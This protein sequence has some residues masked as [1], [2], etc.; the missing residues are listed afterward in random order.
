MHQIWVG[1]LP[2]PEKWMRTWR[3]MHPD[4][5]YR[6]WGNEDL[7]NGEWRNK[8]HMD[9]YAARGIWS[10]VADLMRYEI[11]YRHGGV[12]VAADSECL[13]PLD[14]MEYGQELDLITRE[15]SAEEQL[16]GVHR[17]MEGAR[18]RESTL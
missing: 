16:A 12:L 14:D 1:P 2:P 8:A 5:E 11:L 6:L 17:S 13:R 3:E 18:E 7:A 4:W 9:F 15:L 10:G